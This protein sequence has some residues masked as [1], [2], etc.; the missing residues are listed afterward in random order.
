MFKNIVT[1]VVLAACMAPAFAAVE[2]MTDLEAAKT[3]A[4]AENKA[5]LIDFTGSD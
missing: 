3:K 5:I 1:G 2:W 4:A